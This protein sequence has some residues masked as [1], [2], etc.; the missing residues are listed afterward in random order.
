[1]KIS[2]LHSLLDKHIRTLSLA[3]GER[4][5]KKLDALNRARNYIKDEFLAIGLAV[6]EQVYEFEGVEFANLEAVMPGLEKPEEVII[7]GAHYDSEKGTPGANDNASGVAA[8]LAIA[9]DL[10]DYKPARTIKFV[11]FANEEA[12]YFDTE[13]MGSL[14]YARLAREAGVNIVAMLSLETMA[15]FTAGEGSQKY[16]SG[17]DGLELPEEGNF[18][19]FVS[20]KAGEELLNKL[21]GLFALFSSVPVKSLCAGAEI[22]HAA[23]SDHRSFQQAGYCAVMVTD[24][25]PFRYPYYHHKDDTP[26]KLNMKVYKEVVLGL[27]AC[28]GALAGK[29]G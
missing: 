18:I 19:A 26:D 16:P 11:A 27:T 14:R 25:A 3:I 1:M 24:T 13:G 4:H 2:S 23:L 17:L 22:S 21:T 20:D 5:A 9:H 15:Y 8:M 28:T 10:K 29:V 7:V 12:P 6:D